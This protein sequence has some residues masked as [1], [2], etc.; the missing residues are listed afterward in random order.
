[1]AA[2]VLVRTERQLRDPGPRPWEVGWVLWHYTSPERFYALTLKP[3]GWELSKQDPRYP[4][5]QR[6]LASG[7]TP[8]FPVGGWHRVGI[9]QTGARIDVAADGRFLTRYTDPTS[10]T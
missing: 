9:V 7:R 6:F 4:G 8:T 3:T 2:T 10:R 1:M 5:G